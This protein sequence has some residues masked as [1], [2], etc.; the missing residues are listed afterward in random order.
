MIFLEELTVLQLVNKVPAFYATEILGSHTIT[1][2]IGQRLINDKFSVTSKNIYIY[3]LGLNMTL[4]LNTKD[5]MGGVRSMHVEKRFMQSSIGKT[6]E[7]RPFWK[8]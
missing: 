2:L 3:I 4:L 5:E 7:E 1:D 8:T 6:E